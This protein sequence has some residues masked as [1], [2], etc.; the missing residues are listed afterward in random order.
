MS[1]SPG[2]KGRVLDEV[3]AFLAE[4][5]AEPADMAAED[6]RNFRQ[7]SAEKNCKTCVASRSA[8]PD[9]TGWLNCDRYDFEVSEER[10]CD[11]WNGG[12]PYPHT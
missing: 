10:V 7:G 1:L 12:E 3:A 6:A 4:K 2:A 9:G 11:A 8:R 5:G